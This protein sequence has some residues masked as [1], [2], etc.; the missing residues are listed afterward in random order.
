MEVDIPTAVTG[1]ISIVILVIIV[2]V[3]GLNIFLGYRKSDSEYE[4]RT[5]DRKSFRSDGD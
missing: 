4:K 2:I 5:R 3:L 1:F